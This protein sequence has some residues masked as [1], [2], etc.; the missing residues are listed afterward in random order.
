MTR[1]QI[2]AQYKITNLSPSELFFRGK[3]RVV[4]SLPLGV[5]KQQVNVSIKDFDIV[6]VCPEKEPHW[7]KLIE[8]LMIKM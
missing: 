7:E 1:R 2:W 3:C 5:F 4:R 8:I 6:K